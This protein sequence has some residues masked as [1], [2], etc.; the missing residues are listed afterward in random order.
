MDD[1]KAKILSGI[2]E[3]TGK[4]R[5]SIE[6]ARRRT[7]AQT[8]VS[9]INV[10]AHTNSAVDGFAVRADNLPPLGHTRKLEITGSA[11][12]GQAYT[13]TIDNGQCIRIMTGAPIPK[14]FDT[15]IMQ[16]HAEQHENH[17]L[18]D[19]SH[20]PGQNVRQAGEDLQQGQTVLYAGKML[21]PPDI[22]LVASL[23][24]AEINVKRKL[25]IAIASTGDEIFSIGTTRIK[26]P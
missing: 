18:I 6:R 21:T 9:P 20:Q 16:E 1:A 24:I 8:I 17:I 23:G 4:Q 10:P 2:R 7:L 26:M 13:G 14:I 25:R 22:G 11:L 3:I 12:A 5:L 19:A 15:I